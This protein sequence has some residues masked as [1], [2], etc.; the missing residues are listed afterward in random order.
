M[1]RF[2]AVVIGGGP[3]GL[4]A[5]IAAARAGL[6]VLVADVNEPPIDRLCGEG[7]L[8]D[9]LAALSQLGVP[10]AAAGAQF[11]GISFHENT[12]NFSAAF[13]GH[14]GIGLRRTVLHT[15]L[16]D[17]AERAGVSI[18]FK[19]RAVIESPG[20]VRIGGQSVACHYIVGADGHH[21]LVRDHAG[22][23]IAASKP[24]GLRQRQRIA[25]GMH[26]QCPPWSRF[27]EV[28]WTGNVQ[29]YVTPVRPDE[30]S[31][32]VICRHRQVRADEALALFPVLQDR[33]AT[34]PKISREQGATSH[35]LRLPRV[36]K[37]HIALIGEASGSVDAITGEGLSLIFLQAIAL[38]EALRLGDL[39]HYQREHRKI[40]WRARWMAR[41]L[42][43]LS[44]FPA[45]RSR[46]FQALA[47]E[48]RA[49]QNLLGM[50]VGER[51]KVFGPGG[52]GGLAAQLLLG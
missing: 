42:L 40:L 24:A 19:T 36:V 29:A 32:A 25:S 11:D 18:R 17:A 9:A 34:A 27:V 10:F 44:A 33:L 22:L 2:D 45:W 46:V 43:S 38:G 52:C 39:R 7:L 23:S 5:S 13:P 49:F 4:A 48:P 15:S 31:V 41:L 12:C 6:S 16:V 30:V 20:Q 26:Y 50:H 8:P 14:P 21:S 28:H 1:E 47:T 51:P 3:A 35:M 37:D